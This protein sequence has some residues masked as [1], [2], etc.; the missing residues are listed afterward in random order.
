MVVVVSGQVKGEVHILGRNVRDW[1][2]MLLAGTA[3][4]GFFPT[5]TPNGEGFKSVSLVRTLVVAFELGKLEQI[6]GYTSIID[7]TDLSP[8]LTEN[9][10]PQIWSDKCHQLQ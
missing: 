8:P 3:C 5:W 6:S 4:R 2:L 9:L 10:I 7:I 1:A